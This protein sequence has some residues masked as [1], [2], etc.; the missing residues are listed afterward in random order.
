MKM[1]DYPHLLPTNFIVKINTAKLQLKC[2]KTVNT[3]DVVLSK[4]TEETD[5]VENIAFH[6]SSQL[7]L[8]SAA[9]H[10]RRGWS[11]NKITVFFLL[12]WTS[13]ETRGPQNIYSHRRKSLEDSRETGRTRLTIIDRHRI[14]KRKEEEIGQSMRRISWPRV[15][16]WS[17]GPETHGKPLVTELVNPC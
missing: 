10:Q 4:S 6:Y 17:L 2:T 7:K 8:N 3:W 1:C 13:R 5:T 14:W 11:P 12:R 16:P 9:R 15:C